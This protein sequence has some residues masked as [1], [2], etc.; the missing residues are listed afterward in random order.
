MGNKDF[1]YGIPGGGFINPASF[2][3]TNPGVFLYNIIKLENIEICQAFPLSRLAGL[4]EPAG[5][6]CKQPH[7]AER[8]RSY[9]DLVFFIPA[10]HEKQSNRGR[11]KPPG[12]MM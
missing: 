12:L 7:A 3:L 9:G 10:T 5:D 1:A 11:G 2:S 4:R 8:N 6:G